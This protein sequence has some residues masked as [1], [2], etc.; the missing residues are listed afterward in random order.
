MAHSDLVGIATYNLHGLNS[1]RSGLIDLCNNPQIHIIAIR[2]I[3]LCDS[4]I[5]TLNDIHPDFVA[6]GVSS[7][8]ERLSNEVY[9]GRPYGGVGFY[10]GK[11]TLV[12]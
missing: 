4:N 10:G 11:L 9:R 12:E 1:G 8:T 5:H 7:M 6:F 2:E 3:W